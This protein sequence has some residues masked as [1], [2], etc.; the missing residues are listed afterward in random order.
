M[1]NDLKGWARMSKI[2]DYTYAEKQSAL[3]E[4]WMIMQGHEKVKQDE[5]KRLLQ[6]V[7]RQPRLVR[8]VI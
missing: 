1:Q 4:A 5:G 7:R 2:N 6:E 3:D 8:K